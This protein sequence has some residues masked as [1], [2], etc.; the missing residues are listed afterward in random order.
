MVY[1]LVKMKEMAVIK[2]F[3]E[4]TDVV[5]IREATGTDVSCRAPIAKIG[6]YL[7]D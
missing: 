6:D 1:I 2:I 5:A 7:I 4:T 3:G